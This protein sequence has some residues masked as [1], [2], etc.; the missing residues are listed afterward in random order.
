MEWH[1]ANGWPKPKIPVENTAELQ[2]AAIQSWLRQETCAEFHEY[3][4]VP[5]K[6]DSQG[7]RLIQDAW[8]DAVKAYETE[9]GTDIIGSGIFAKE[10]ELQIFE[11][12][13]GKHSLR[14]WGSHYSNGMLTV[15]YEFM[16]PN[17]SRSCAA[18]LP[19]WKSQKWTTEKVYELAMTEFIPI[20]HDKPI[21]S[22][23]LEESLK[24]QL[25]IWVNYKSQTPLMTVFVEQKKYTFSIVP[26]SNLGDRSPL[27]WIAEENGEE[28]TYQSGPWMNEDIE[29]VAL[30]GPWGPYKESP[31]KIVF[32][33][34]TE[35]EIIQTLQYIMEAWCRVEFE[36]S[37]LDD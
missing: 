22:A 17:G 34:M 24:L 26:N 32:K 23:R 9:Q 16:R 6:G 31:T 29:R 2:E 21:V 36:T 25:F 35:K 20:F 33:D 12:K 8:T 13:Q 1:E 4:G 3:L 27:R 37:L 18:S 10:E 11:L 14:V 15:G 7:R 28:A 19:F 30:G 5:Y